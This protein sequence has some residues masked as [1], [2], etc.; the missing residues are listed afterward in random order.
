MPRCAGYKGR[1]PDLVNYSANSANSA[2]ASCNP[3][4]IS[5]YSVFALLQTAINKV[6]IGSAKCKFNKINGLL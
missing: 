2:N 1:V 5:K 3:M 6:Q 4:F